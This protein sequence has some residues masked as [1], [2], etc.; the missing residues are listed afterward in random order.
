MHLCHY[1]LPVA[2]KELAGRIIANRKPSSIVCLMADEDHDCNE[3]PIIW[4]VFASFKYELGI[5]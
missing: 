1:Q 5:C 3:M 4:A 2:I